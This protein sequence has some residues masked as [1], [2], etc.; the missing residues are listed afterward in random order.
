FRDSV[1][2]KKDFL[3]FAEVDGAPVGFFDFEIESKEKGYFVFYII[4]SMRGRGIGFLLL[5]S[6]LK[7]PEVKKVKLLEAGVEDYNFSSIKTLERSGF[8][9]SYTDEDGMLMYQKKLK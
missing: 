4:P 1:D 9:Y 6:A 3:W 5:N 7:I 8:E 2:F